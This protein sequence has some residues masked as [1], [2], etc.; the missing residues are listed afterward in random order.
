[1]QGHGVTNA[2]DGQGFWEPK[3]GASNPHMVVGVGVRVVQEGLP[4]E[5]DI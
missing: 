2:T 5:G 4:G 3:E 1:M